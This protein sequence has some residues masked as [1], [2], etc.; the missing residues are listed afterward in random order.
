MVSNNNN[1]YTYCFR[2]NLF[3]LNEM[4]EKNHNTVLKI[5]FFLISLSL[6]LAFVIEYGLG[7]EPCKLCLYQR[8]PYLAAIFISFIGYNYNKNNKIL[9]LIVLI[10]TLN[11]LISGY[12]YGIENN[13]FV[14]FSGCTNNSLGTIDKKELLLSLNNSLPNCKDVNFKVFGLSLATINFI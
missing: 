4:I 11:F 13:I 9:L 10:F 14:E 8:V 6:I 3:L 5:V 12:H 7:H 2:A 1:I